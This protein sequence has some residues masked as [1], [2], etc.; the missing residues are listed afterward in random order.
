MTRK[1]NGLRKRKSLKEKEENWKGKGVMEEGVR[2]CG[3]EIVS[4]KGKG[5]QRKGRS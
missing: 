2:L 4:R 5:G 3:G 1:K